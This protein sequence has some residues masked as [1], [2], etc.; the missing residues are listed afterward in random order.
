M[1]DHSLYNGKPMRLFHGTF[2]YGT[3]GKFLTSD[4]IGNYYL[5][6]YKN[7]YNVPAAGCSNRPMVARISRS[8]QRQPQAAILF[9]ILVPTS[10]RFLPS[11][12]DS[13]R[14]CSMRRAA[15]TARRAMR[16]LR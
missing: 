11:C 15:V 1:A 10:A 16:Q 4:G 13:P 14:S 9:L 2:D 12:R 6:D 5:Y 3:N 7:N 8:S